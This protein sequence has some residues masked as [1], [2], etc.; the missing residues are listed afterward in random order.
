M[1]ALKE[2]FFTLFGHPI[3]RPA[4]GHIIFIARRRLVYT[5]T[6]LCSDSR[7]RPDQLHLPTSVISRLV[8][9]PDILLI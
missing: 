7:A 6:G 9:H 1:Y 2:C 5:D 3:S 4:K 8:R